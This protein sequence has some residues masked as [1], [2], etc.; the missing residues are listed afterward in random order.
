MAA[1]FFTRW[2]ARPLYAI[3]GGYEGR[4]NQFASTG[5]IATYFLSVSTQ[6]L[7]ESLDIVHSESL[8]AIQP[9]VST[10]FTTMVGL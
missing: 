7:G 3:N 9:G 4:D 2:R 6:S 1:D 5:G 8:L 10:L